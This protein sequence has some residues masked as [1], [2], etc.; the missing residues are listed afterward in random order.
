MASSNE[1]TD[2][3]LNYY[4][5]CYLT[6]DILAE[7]LREIFKQEWDKLYKSTLLGG[8]EDK[9]LN[10]MD[11]Y[12]C[13]SPRNQRRNAHILATVKNGNRGDWD[14]KI[15]FYAILFSNC[16]GPT[17]RA[18]VRK[19]V[20]DLRKFRIEFALMR[21]GSL[22]EIDFQNAISKVEVAFQA[23]SLSTVK[24][25]DLKYQ[26][27]FQTKDLTKVRKEVDDLKQE[28]QQR[29]KLIGFSDSPVA[30]RFFGHHIKVP[31]GSSFLHE[32]MGCFNSLLCT[33]C[34]AYLLRSPS[35]SYIKYFLF[36]VYILVPSK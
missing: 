18:T 21:Q 30:E 26:K 13:E 17:L 16:V 11:F 9:P 20:D 22:S 23:L 19:N 34:F 28:V 4:R 35:F 15:L 2:E 14:C 24:I 36:T 27:T 7:G 8:W 5:I 25:Q 6:T 12:N 31:G 33:L 3:Q 1:Y 10:G 32:N 29:R